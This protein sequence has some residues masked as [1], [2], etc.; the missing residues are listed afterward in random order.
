M[1]KYTELDLDTEI[2][3]KRIFHF[4]E[5]S[6]TNNFSRELVEKGAEEGTVVVADEQT[7]G[8]GRKER[9]WYSPRG[10]LWFSIILYPNFIQ[11]DRSILLTMAASISTAES[12]NALADVEGKIKWPNDVLIGK[13][14]VC[15]ILTE[16]EADVDEIHHA[17]IG[18]GLNVNNE[19]NQDLEEKA[20]TLLKETGRNLSGEDVL[21]AILGNFEDL[22][23]RLKNRGTRQIKKRWS[24]L[25]AIHQKEVLV[26]KGSKKIQGKVEGIDD[27]GRL[28]LR[29]EA[30]EHSI[31]TGDVE[32]L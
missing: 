10:G 30:G 14:K 1:G 11:T 20:T 12:I 29:S 7:M 28:V 9:T 21:R 2:I 13:K 17:I 26:E 25:S 15:G 3:G 31:M 32:I 6:S 23:F 4:D 27:R 18:I 16:M 24:D 5:L 8:K 19:L 22:Y